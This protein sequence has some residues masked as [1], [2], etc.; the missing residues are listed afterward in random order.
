MSL[1]NLLNNR[2]SKKIFKSKSLKPLVDSRYGLL[3]GNLSRFYT[4]SGIKFINKY[5]EVYTTRLH[6]YILSVLLDKKVH[7]MDNS[8]GKN[9]N[10]Y[11]TW[12]VDFDK[13]Y[14]I[15]NE[16]SSKEKLQTKAMAAY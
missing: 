2:I 7:M 1:V 11:Y 5:D 14:F 9:S 13:S 15:S 10:F 16:T 3:R 6:G 4:M 12:M 8:Y